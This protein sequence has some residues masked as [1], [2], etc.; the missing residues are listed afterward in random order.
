MQVLDG[1]EVEVFRDSVTLKSGLAFDESFMQAM[2]QCLVVVPLITP[3]TLERMKPFSGLNTVDHVLLEWWLAMTLVA[4]PGFP[5]YR[6]APILCGAVG[7]LLCR[8]RVLF[9]EC[10]SQVH[11]E[12]SSLAIHDLFEELNYNDFPDQV[13]EPTLTRL[14]QFLKSVKLPEVEGVTV[15]KLVENMLKMRV[16]DECQCWRVF[17]SLCVLD[18]SH[19]SEEERRTKRV[20]E[21][22]RVVVSCSRGVFGIMQESYKEFKVQSKAGRAKTLGKRGKQ[23]RMVRV[24]AMVSTQH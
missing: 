24:P 22:Q 9:N 17:N 23:V 14:N 1:H 4:I 19:L 15:R 13:N 6:I 18:A 8:R 11:G 20:L 5:V 12:G 2:L 3:D 16:P 21:L 7:L 10:C